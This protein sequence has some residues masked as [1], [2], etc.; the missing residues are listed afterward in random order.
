MK[1][2]RLTPRET[3]H[4]WCHNCIQS[5]LDTEVENCEG[6]FVY[7]TGRPCPFFPYRMGKRPHMKVFRQ[8]CLDCMGG[9]SA[10]VKEC[11]KE[12]CLMKHYRFG[13]NPF[14]RGGSK[15]QMDS[16]RLPGSTFSPVKSHE[17]PLFLSGEGSAKDR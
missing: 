9:S 8:F 6:Q 17:K 16:I 14:I 3:I 15:E 1:T 5:R 11:E 10:L 4:A 12:N 7:A 2:G 13:K